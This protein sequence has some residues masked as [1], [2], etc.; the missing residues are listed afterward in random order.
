V[1]V[2]PSLKFHKDASYEIIHLYGAIREFDKHHWPQLDH[3]LS[4][5]Q[6]WALRDDKKDFNNVIWRFLPAGENQI[7]PILERYNTLLDST[8][9]PMRDIS[10]EAQNCLKE[11]AFLL[12]DIIWSCNNIIRKGID[13]TIIEKDLNFVENIVNDFRINEMKNR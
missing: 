10:R 4:E 12:N 8:D 3:F 13:S 1:T 7:P 11:A 5:N 2:Y 6:S 9:I